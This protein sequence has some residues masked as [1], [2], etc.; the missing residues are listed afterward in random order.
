MQPIRPILND[1]SERPAVPSSASIIDDIQRLVSDCEPVELGNFQ[2]NL[3]NFKF[4]REDANA[5]SRR[6]PSAKLK[7]KTTVVGDVVSSLH[8]E[9][10]WE[11]M[12]ERTARQ[13]EG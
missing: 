8:T 2:L 5:R 7:G 12:F 4:D 1:A 11:T 13:I 10:E 9:E 3:T 6:K